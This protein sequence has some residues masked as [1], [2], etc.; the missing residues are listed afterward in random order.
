MVHFSL[1]GDKMVTFKTILYMDLSKT[2]VKK[3]QKTK[4]N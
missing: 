2:K 3:T 4:R 1:Y